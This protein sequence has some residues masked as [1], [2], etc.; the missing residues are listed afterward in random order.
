M[1]FP[2]ASLANPIDVAGSTDAN[3]RLLAT[4]AEILCQDRNVDQVFWLVCSAA[5][6]FVSPR[7]G[8]R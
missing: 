4:C 7:V 3:P 1:L 5:T 2:Q 8:R 6:A